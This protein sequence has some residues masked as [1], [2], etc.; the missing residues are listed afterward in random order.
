MPRKHPG[1]KLCS[2]CKSEKTYDDFQSRESKNGYRVNS[3]CKVCHGEHQKIARE[4]KKK[5]S[6]RRIQ[7]LRA[8]R[9]EVVRELIVEHLKQNPC[10]KCGQTNILCLDFDHR[11]PN[12]KS[13]CIS[14]A[15]N[16]VPSI[17]RLKDEIAKCDILCA[18]CHRIKTAVD[19]GNFKTKLGA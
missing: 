6:N 16:L 3:W 18:N 13:F 2:R 8:I 17:K 4:P 5:E 10:L 1:K 9:R 7:E 15:V 11:Q 14:Q 19:S 12:L